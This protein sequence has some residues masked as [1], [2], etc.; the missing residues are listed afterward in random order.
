MVKKH[1]ENVSKEYEDIIDYI[2]PKIKIDEEWDIKVL[3][4]IT[5]WEILL[6]G[7]NLHDEYWVSWS[8]DYTL[9]W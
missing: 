2:S 9:V 8:L 6:K 3:E 1:Y 5:K 7:E 4:H